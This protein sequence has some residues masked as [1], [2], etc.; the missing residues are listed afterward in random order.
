[1]NTC[2]QLLT[3]EVKKKAELLLYPPLQAQVET[4]GVAI[5]EKRQAKP[6]GLRSVQATD[7][8]EYCFMYHSSLLS[9][10]LFPRTP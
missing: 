2:D 6:G 8:T 10:V 3:S 5:N 7:I 9:S 4:V 1:M